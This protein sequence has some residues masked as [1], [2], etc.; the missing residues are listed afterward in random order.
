MAEFKSKEVFR[1]W[2][3]EFLSGLSPLEIQKKNLYS[4]EHIEELVKAC[5]GDGSKLS[6]RRLIR[7]VK[8]RKFF[9]PTEGDNKGRLCKYQSDKGGDARAVA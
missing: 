4:P 3:N 2:I 6:N 5:T 1:A 7:T 9:V 8:D